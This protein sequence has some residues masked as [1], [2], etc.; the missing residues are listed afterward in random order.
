M[1]T[2]ICYIGIDSD[3]QIPTEEILINLINCRNCCNSY[4]LKYSLLRL[5]FTY[6]FEIALLTV[7]NIKSNF[8]DILKLTAF[9]I[10]NIYL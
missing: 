5:G 3:L 7:R 9:V 2:K 8:G 4:N 6:E 1:T 10:F